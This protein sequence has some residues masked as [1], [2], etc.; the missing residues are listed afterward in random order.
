MAPLDLGLSGNDHPAWAE[1]VP[2]K[3]EGEVGQVVLVF[4]EGGGRVF[5]GRPAEGVEAVGEEAPPREGA[6]R[7]AR[8]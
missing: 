2:E 7:R 5:T 6:T 8:R 1:A 3:P 4:G